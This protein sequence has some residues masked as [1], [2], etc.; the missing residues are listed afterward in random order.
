MDTNLKQD[1][2]IGFILG[3]LYTKYKRANDST[4]PKSER[5]P[6]S[7]GLQFVIDRL[8]ST[9]LDITKYPNTSLEKLREAFDKPIANLNSFMERAPEY[10]L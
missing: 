2:F 3:E 5:V 7:Q 1:S 6:L 10:L 9:K 4:V 8:L